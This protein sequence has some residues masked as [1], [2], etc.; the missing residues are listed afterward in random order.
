MKFDQIRTDRL[1]IRR[2]R[3][4][5][6]KQISRYRSIPEVAEF[7]SWSEYSEEEAIELVEQTRGSEPDVEGKWFQFGVEDPETAVLIGDI[8]VLN[9][10]EDGRSWIGFTLDSSY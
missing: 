4:E 9:S 10:D 6:A 7:Q 8:G 5:D 3:I 2:L 1:V